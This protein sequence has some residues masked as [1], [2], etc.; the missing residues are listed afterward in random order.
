MKMVKPET[1]EKYG[2]R[3]TNME[4]ERN[5]LV[6][7]LVAFS[8]LMENRGGVV[9]KSPDYVVEKYVTAMA[10]SVDLLHQMHDQ[11]NKRKYFK[12]LEM[13]LT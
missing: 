3:R 12:Y 10:L 2:K 5:E 6:K 4:K 8:I 9:T 7:R 13:W 11:V 1:A